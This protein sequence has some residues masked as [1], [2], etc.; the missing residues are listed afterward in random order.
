M[1]TQEIAA[2]IAK[3]DPQTQGE[4][5]SSSPALSRRIK[6][7]PLLTERG[8]KAH[9]FIMFSLQL[10]ES[11]TSFNTRNSEK[12]ESNIILFSPK[13]SPISQ[14]ATRRVEERIESK[15]SI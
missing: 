1:N 15:R 2:G 9:L 3:N 11:G 14:L 4:D 6:V 7:N 10:I 13:N 8:I 5:I 12:K